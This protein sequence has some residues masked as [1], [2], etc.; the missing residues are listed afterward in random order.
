MKLTNHVQAFMQR[1]PQV[2]EWLKDRP[3]STQIKYGSALK[4]FCDSANISPTDFQDL[5]KKRA[6]I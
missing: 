1:H 4:R 3:T 6:L 5:E 2:R